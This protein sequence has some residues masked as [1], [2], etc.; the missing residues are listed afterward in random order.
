MAEGFRRKTYVE[1]VADMEAKA[2]EVFGDNISL[3]ES[4]P[5]GMYIRSTAWELSIA[6]EEMERSHYSHYGQWAT[7]QDLDNIVANFGRKRFAGTKATVDLSFEGDIG[8]IVPVGFRVSTANDLTFETVEDIELTGVD[9]IVQ[10]QAIEIGSKYNVPAE[11]ITEIVNPE[12]DITDVINVTEAL[13]GTDIETDD[14][15]RERH[16]Q[17]IREPVTGDNMAQYNQWAR[18]VN[19][20]GNLRVLPTT[21]SAGYTTLIIAASSGAVPS[22]EL[23]TNVENYIEEVRPVNAGVVVEGAVAKNITISATIR[24]ATGYEL[25]PVKEEFERLVKEYFKSI[26]M[27]DS[28]VSYAQIG[29]L[30]LETTGMFDYQDLLLNAQAG[31]VEL[32]Q[33]EIPIL[34]NV[35]FEVV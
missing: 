18:E 34:S 5:L 4:S 10:A 7:G 17:A 9:D 13:G 26:A 6:W 14:N 25:Q 2:R 30:L 11:A 3:E 33:N 16:L 31:N 22:Q 35:Q 27:K 20:V 23:L 19:G 12:V 21:P 8:A 28:Y 24:L 32:A 29:R 15:L 1:I